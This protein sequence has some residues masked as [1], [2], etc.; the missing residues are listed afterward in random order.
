MKEDKTEKQL[1]NYNDVFADVMNY[2]LYKGERKIDD[3]SLTDVKDRSLYSGT[4]QIREQE[5]DVSK[6]YKNKEMHIAFLGIENQSKDEK[7]MP[8]RVISYDGSVYRSQLIKSLEGK[9]EIDTYPVITLVLYFGI[10]PWSEAKTLYEAIDVP[11][12]LKEYV[13]DYRLNILEVALMDSEDVEKFT[14]DFRLIADFFVQK[15]KMGKYIPPNIPIKHM[16]AFLK[17][18]S[19][20]VGDKRYREILDE[21]NANSE[22]M[23]GRTMCEIYDQIQNEGIEIGIEQGIEKGK[24]EVLRGLFLDNIITLSEAAKRAGMDES[25]FEEL[26]KEKI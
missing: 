12:D 3:D 24:I 8:L 19:D 7:Y 11:D 20:M 22:N 25:E 26:L 17:M 9:K 10:K 14:S 4:G 5:R 18:L 15:R 21:M 23:E 1:I 6:I 13:N 16:D 2:Y